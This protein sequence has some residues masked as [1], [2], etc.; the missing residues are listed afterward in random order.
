MLRRFLILFLGALLAIFSSATE[1]QTALAQKGQTA[2][3]RH[4]KVTSGPMVRSVT[5]TTAEIAWSTNVNSDTLLRY[6]KEE[7]ALSE[8]A[9]SPWGGRTHR[10]ALANLTPDTTYYFRVGT[11]SPQQTEPMAGTANFRTQPVRKAP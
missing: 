11:S 4:V 9:Q 7:N 2:P 8:T 3:P 1:G 10:V 5:D 6:G